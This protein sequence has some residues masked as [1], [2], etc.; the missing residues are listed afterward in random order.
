MAKEP[1]RLYYNPI[2]K[3]VKTVKTSMYDVTYYSE[4]SIPDD[5]SIT[6]HA[7]SHTIDGENADAI[8]RAF[9]AG[10][11]KLRQIIKTS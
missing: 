4:K 1:R 5:R 7:I 9:K 8:F 2:A 10:M 3:T 6:K 11:E